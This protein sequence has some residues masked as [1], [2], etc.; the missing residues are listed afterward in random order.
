M[1]DPGGYDKTGVLFLYYNK[2]LEKNI[3]SWRNWEEFNVQVD[4][5]EIDASGGLVVGGGVVVG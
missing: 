2:V 5:F 1:K 4:V 3:E